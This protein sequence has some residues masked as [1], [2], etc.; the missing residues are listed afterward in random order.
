MSGKSLLEQTLYV[1]GDLGD[2]TKKPA[3]PG[4]VLNLGSFIAVA[5]GLLQ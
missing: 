2:F 5:F 3:C 1:L 4:Y